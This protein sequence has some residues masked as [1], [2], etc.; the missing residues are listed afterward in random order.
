MSGDIWIYSFYYITYSLFM[1]YEGIAPKE[2]I[3]RRKIEIARDLLENTPLSIIEIASASGFPDV[4]SFSRLFK[5]KTGMS[6]TK[7]RKL[8]DS[9]VFSVD[10]L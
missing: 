9:K 3:L 6:P 8:H 1:Q 7:F 10:I 2:Y 4:Y 5:V